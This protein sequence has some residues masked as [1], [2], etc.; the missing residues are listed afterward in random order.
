MGWQ[1]ESWKAKTMTNNIVYNLSV[2]LENLAYKISHL[3]D[4]MARLSAHI[5]EIKE[6]E[7]DGKFRRLV[8]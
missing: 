8:S 5:E 1:E 7:S 3:Q 4:E 6:G 2:E